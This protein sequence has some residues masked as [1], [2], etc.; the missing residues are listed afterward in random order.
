MDQFLKAVFMSIL[1]TVVVP[2]KT[3]AFLHAFP[4]ILCKW[5]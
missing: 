1:K 5:K 2:L 4:H 3:E